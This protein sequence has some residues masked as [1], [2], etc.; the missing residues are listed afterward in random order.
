[1]S[2]R[3]TPRAARLSRVASSRS[4]SAW[5]RSSGVRTLLSART[6]LRL[7]ASV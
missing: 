6:T 4:R 1:M 2:G 5:R 3:Q 7:P